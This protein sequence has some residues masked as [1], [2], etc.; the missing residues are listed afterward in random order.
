MAS[1][2]PSPLSC[3]LATLGLA[4]AC[5]AP[6]SMRH[7]PRS[8]PLWEDAD[9]QPLLMQPAEYFSPLAWDGADQT[10]FRPI[11]RIFAVDPP[12]GA[13]NVNALDEVPDSSW[14]TNRIGR[15]P[16]TPEQ[17]ATGPCE[18]AP[19][20]PAGPWTVTGAKPN[21]ANPGFFIKDQAGRRYLLKYDG[22]VQGP[23]ATAA[24]VLVSKLYYA[25]GYF[26]PCNQVV[27]FDRSILRI[28][29]K[30][31]GENAA[32][33]EEPLSEAHLDTIFAKA[34]RLGDGRY[35]ASASRF[36]DGVPLGPWRYQGKRKDDPNDV[37]RHEDRR[38]LRGAR[39]LA[40]WVNHFDARE[41]NTMA[42]WMET[43]DGRGHVRHYYLDF[44]DCL[45]SIWEPPMLGRRIGHSSYFDPAHVAADFVTLGLIERPWDRARFGP[46]GTVLGYFDVQSFDPDRYHT[47]YP[48][49]A[50]ARMREAD[51]AWM[52]R[53][54][55][56]LDDQRLQAAISTARLGDPSL[57]HLLL[58]VLAGRRDIL[59]RRYLGRLS[60]LAHP[61]TQEVN[62]A[63]E[64]CLRDLAVEGGVADA[65]QRLYGARLW[66]ND[67]PLGTLGPLTVRDGQGVCVALPPELP[68]DT[69]VVVD[70]HAGNASDRVL[71][72]TRVHLLGQEPH[73][74]QV[75]GLERPES[76]RSTERR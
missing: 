3:I 17:I 61:I 53:I 33:H 66:V 71:P 37:V 43:I 20:D 26:A 5:A 46:S 63:T 25:A 30:A 50:F 9:R 49:P 73:G 12:H 52:A 18:E 11:T 35:R 58:E 41:Q 54:I 21:G 1:K 42:T 62:G 70:V 69:Y 29:P 68:T 72:P 23:R 51:G 13:V 64:L 34:M 31:E 27:F 56:Q 59:L 4:T 57:E 16:M 10:F 65:N 32:G 40:A 48:N 55:S 38:E 6:T 60:P 45:G 14:F 28:D 47:G 67:K 75:V 36:L 44:G 7:F 8:K 2:R 76:P 74:L 39:V 22:V 19:L 15:F 24:D